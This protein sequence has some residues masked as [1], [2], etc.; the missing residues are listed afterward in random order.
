MEPQQAIALAL[1]AGWASGLNLYAAVLVLGGLHATGYASLP[2][3]LQVL[4]NPMVLLIAGAM[5]LVEFCV[6]K[7]PGVDTVWDGIHTFIRVPAG[8]I[9]AA[10]SVGHVHPAV[11]FAAALAGGGLAAGSH[12]TK[13][14]ARAFV[15]F[16]PEPFSNWTLSISEDL[17]VIGGLWSAFNYP[18]G[19][20]AALVVFVAIMAALLPILLKALQ[21]VLKKVFG[22]RRPV[23]PP[24]TPIVSPSVG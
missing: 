20:L 1:G 22:R 12:F 4:A 6:D 16:S 17:L 7:V 3:D 21:R 15:N 5:Y 18:W 24:I 10:Q 2:P 14:G 13:A 23:E 19:F 9:L 8:A 11:A